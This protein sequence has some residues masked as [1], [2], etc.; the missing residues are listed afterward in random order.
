MNTP[1]KSLQIENVPI[2]QNKTLILNFH[3]SLLFPKGGIFEFCPE[4]EV[5]KKR[6]ISS[7]FFNRT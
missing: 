7:I 1:V 6:K 5:V 4:V 3:F 2:K